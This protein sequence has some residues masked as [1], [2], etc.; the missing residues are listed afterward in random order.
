[1]HLSLFFFIS[2]FFEPMLILLFFKPP[3]IIFL[4]LTL[5]LIQKNMICN[6]GTCNSCLR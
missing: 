1:M 4:F 6:T 2:L 5:P 3:C